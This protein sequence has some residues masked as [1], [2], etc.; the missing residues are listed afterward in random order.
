MA[1]KKRQLKNILI[2]P[3]FQ[4]KL[5]SYFVVLFA[6]TTV[7]FYSVILIFFQRLKQKGLNVGLSPNHVFFDFLRHQKQDV[8]LL[9]IGLTVLNF[10]LLIGVGFI[11]SH[12]IAGPIHNLKNYLGNTL[13][14]DSVDFKLRKNDFL[15][16]LVPIINKLKTKIK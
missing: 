9:F 6:I 11:V 8:D 3:Q 12:R 7:S 14:K 4:L 10:L 1:Q 2:E 15:T 5:L 16:D 13:S